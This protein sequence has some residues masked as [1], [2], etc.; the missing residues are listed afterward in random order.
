VS[1]C[2]EYCKT[3][4]RVHGSVRASETFACIA[5]VGNPETCAFDA[6]SN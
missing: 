2:H 1:S 3:A 6:I 5:T 4:Q